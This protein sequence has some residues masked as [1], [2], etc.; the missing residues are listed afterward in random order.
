MAFTQLD[1]LGVEH[2]VDG[3]GKPRVRLKCMAVKPIEAYANLSKLSDDEKQPYLDLIG[4]RAMIPCRLSVMDTGLAFFVLTPQDGE[5]IELPSP[6]SK[7]VETAKSP[8]GVIPPV[9]SMK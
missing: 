9:S 8:A 5:P 4:K 6:V 2:D 3:D 7:P 1:V